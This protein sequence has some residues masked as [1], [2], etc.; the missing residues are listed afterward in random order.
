MLVRSLNFQQSFSSRLRT[1]CGVLPGAT[2]VEDFGA[3]LPQ[4][5]MAID[6]KRVEVAA[7]VSKTRR[8]AAANIVQQLRASAPYV[9]LHRDS[10]MV[11]HLCICAVWCYISAN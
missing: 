11:V 10:N 8:A 2:T 5:E 1:L 4:V 6:A 9:D 3:P 7:S